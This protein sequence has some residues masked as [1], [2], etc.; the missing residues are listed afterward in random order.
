ML[1]EKNITSPHLTKPQHK[2]INL[3]ETGFLQQLCAGK[4]DITAP[5]INLANSPNNSANSLWRINQTNKMLRAKKQK[6]RYRLYISANTPSAKSNVKHYLENNKR[7]ALRV[8]TTPASF[9]RG[10]STEASQA[11]A[12]SHIPSPPEGWRDGA[13]STQRYAEGLA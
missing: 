5:R 13:Y 11:S 9:R 10:A 1:Q 4:H 3:H 12:F 2:A 6:E 8:K 7:M